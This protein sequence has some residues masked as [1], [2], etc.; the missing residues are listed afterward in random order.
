[1][2]IGKSAAY[3]PTIPKLLDALTDSGAVQ[4]RSFFGT[5]GRVEVAAHE[6]GAEEYLFWSESPIVRFF[7]VNPNFWLRIPKYSRRAGRGCDVNF[8]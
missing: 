1:M 3:P 4:V 7:N 6:L 2:H 8:G 5:R